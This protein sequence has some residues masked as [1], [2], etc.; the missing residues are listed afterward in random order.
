[1]AIKTREELIAQ[2]TASFGDST[3]NE[4]IALIEDVTDTIKDLETKVNGDG[5]DWK[6]EAEKIDK[7]WREKYV[8]RF[9]SSSDNEDNKDEQNDDTVKSYNYEDLFKQGDD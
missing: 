5:K 2:V 6:A 8:K 9:S 3:S 4:A 7:E 1:M